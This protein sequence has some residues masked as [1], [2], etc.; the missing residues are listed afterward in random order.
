MTK[1][2]APLIRVSLATIGLGLDVYAFHSSLDL[3]FLYVAYVCCEAVLL[4]GRLLANVLPLEPVPGSGIA[5]QPPSPPT[6]LKRLAD[7][8]EGD[9][10]PETDVY[11]LLRPILREAA[12]GRLAASHGILLDKQ[13]SEARE[14]LGPALWDLLRPDPPLPRAKQA[15][16][17]RELRDLVE[18]VA[19]I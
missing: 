12:Q 1:L 8:V 4:I 9:T 17:M 6:Q 16:K 18:G 3:I 5:R 7:M 2:R 13:R 15:W 10:L 14:I 19:S 11:A